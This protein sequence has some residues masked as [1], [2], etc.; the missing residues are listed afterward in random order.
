MATIAENLQTIKDSTESIKQA[1]IDKGGTISGGLITYADAIKNISGGGEGGGGN[2][3][4]F[5]ITNKLNGYL[6]GGPNY[7]TQGVELLHKYNFEGGVV[8]K[9]IIIPDDFST[10]SGSI[11]LNYNTPDSSIQTEEYPFYIFINDKAPSYLVSGIFY[12]SINTEGQLCLRAPGYPESTKPMLLTIIA[13]DVDGNYDFDYVQIQ[14]SM[15]CFLRDTQITLFDNSQKK[16]QDITYNDELKV[17]DFDNGVTSKAK[18]LWI[19]KQ[20]IA[21]YYYKVTLEDGNTI[22]LVGS[23]GKCHRLFNYDDMV[24]ESATDMVGKNTYTE[25]GICRIVSVDKVEEVCE[26]YNIITNYHMN[27]FA[28][29]ILSSCRY[30]NLYPMKDMRFVKDDRLSKQ[31]R[32]KVYAEKFRQ[33]PVLGTY[34]DGLR[35]YEQEDIS[36]EDTVKYVNN[37]EL[38][39]KRL[40][41]FDENYTISNDI[42]EANVGWIDLE[43]NVY[44]FKLYMP[45]QMNHI[46]LADIIGSELGLKEESYGGYSRTLENL[47]W[48]KFSNDFLSYSNKKEI[49]TKQERML[50]KFLHNNEKVKKRGS[51]KMGSVLGDDNSLEYL[52]L[53]PK[54]DLTN[55]MRGN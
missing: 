4:S 19:K 32:W 6:F 46:L 24:F 25:N 40:T 23:N 1:I 42:S 33:H 49:S 10:Q 47:G 55:K 9:V 13:I 14:T 15:T 44:G 11:N 17:W 54:K 35:L 7:S 16:V 38:L 21:T 37:L 53:M 45:G 34:L 2:T 48:V 41:D 8:D 52:K 18:P 5:R 29:G 30:N 43:G 50:F 36:I 27:C 39:K 22:N 31:P 20:E 12:L 51:I 26:Y 28:N 3:S